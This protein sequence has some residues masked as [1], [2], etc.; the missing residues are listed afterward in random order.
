MRINASTITP[1]TTRTPRPSPSE[2]EAAE[3]GFLDRPAVATVEPDGEKDASIDANGDPDC[4]VPANEMPE[5]SPPVEP[6]PLPAWLVR[7]SEIEAA[8]GEL[9]MKRDD[10]KDAAKSNREAISAMTDE[11]RFH[12]ARDPRK[13]ETLPLFA[14][15]PAPAV[16]ECPRG[17]A[18]EPDEDGDCKKCLEPIIPNWR[19]TAIK[20]VP[21]LTPKLVEIIEAEGIRTLADWVDWPSKTGLEYTQIE[22]M[23]EKRYEKVSE[24]IIKATT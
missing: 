23:T 5:T 1:D 3:V 16:E 15:P 10:I 7:K 8:L 19:K 22:G 14:T 13:A 4:E 17:G 21:G 11:L 18:H 6:D 20:D 2:S 12:L 24:A 9:N